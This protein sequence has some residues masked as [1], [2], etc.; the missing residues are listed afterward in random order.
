MIIRLELLKRFYVKFKT[1]MNDGE[2]YILHAM[3]KDSWQ[4]IVPSWQL[5]R[6]WIINLPVMFRYKHDPNIIF[7]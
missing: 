2:T 5:R 6:K 3:I 7:S 1:I 4:P